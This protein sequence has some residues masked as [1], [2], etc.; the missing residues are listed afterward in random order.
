[1]ANS[2]L[3]KYQKAWLATEKQRKGLTFGYADRFTVARFEE[4]PGARMACYS[5]SYAAID[6]QKIRR[7]VGEYWALVKRTFGSITLP[8][9]FTAQDVADMFAAYDDTNALPVCYDGYALPMN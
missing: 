1:M 5:I 6:E 9:K 4:F 2:K 3:D 8:A 7:K